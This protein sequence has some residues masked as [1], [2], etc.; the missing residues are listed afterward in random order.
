MNSRPMMRPSR[1]KRPP[2]P[3]ASRGNWSP[4]RSPMVS[5]NSTC[6]CAMASRFTTSA[7]AWFS[8]RSDF[9]NFSRAGTL[10]NRSRTSMM[11]PGLPAAGRAFS[12]ALR[13][14]VMAKASEAPCA[15]ERSVSLAMEPI[16]G[17]ASPRKPSVRMANRSSSASLEVAC[18]STD[19]A[20]SP[21]PMPQPLS[22][23]R[24]RLKPPEAVTT[25]ISVEPA[26]SAFSTSSFT[27][28]AGRSMTSPAAM[29]LIVSGDSWRMATKPPFA[30]RER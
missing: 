8:A 11:V 28:L 13:S 10:E 5:V 12:L 17:S 7:T 30:P 27:T 3:C 21:G 23:T 16:E 15:R 4:A 14:T 9:R 2:A 19:S 26:S 25:S 18:R 22:V 6:G 24:M 20:R 1:C 29:R